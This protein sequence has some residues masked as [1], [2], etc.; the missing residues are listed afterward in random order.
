MKPG[1]LYIGR[2]NEDR[3]A[4]RCVMRCLNFRAAKQLVK[5]AAE[6]S[7]SE[8]SFVLNSALVNNEFSSD[9]D[10]ESDFT[11][12][13]P[14]DSHVDFSS[15]SSSIITAKNLVS[16]L[17]TLREGNTSHIFSNKGDILTLALE[18]ALDESKSILKEE[19]LQDVL[20]LVEACF[21]KAEVE[22]TRQKA[23]ILEREFGMTRSSNQ[24]VTGKT[25]W[26]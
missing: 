15:I 1:R 13:E 8:S 26:L 10:S 23:V 14:Y 11:I 18:A 25:Y 24:T 4:D 2:R 5:M 3:R 12:S 7:S 20:R 16:C 9:D 19:F 21:T 6:M 22:K 17:Q